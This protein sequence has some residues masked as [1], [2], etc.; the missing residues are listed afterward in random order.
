MGGRGF[1]SRVVF[2]F[3]WVSS[4]PLIKRIPKSWMK[5]LFLVYS[6]CRCFTKHFLH[7]N[8]ILRRC[9]ISN[10]HISN[11]MLLIDREVVTLVM[12]HIAWRVTRR[13]CLGCGGR[14]GFQRQLKFSFRRFEVAWALVC[15]N[16][17]PIVFVGVSSEKENR[18][19][20]WIT[21]A[22]QGRVSKVVSI[23]VA[24]IKIK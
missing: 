20:H 19:A 3:G 15:I 11:E 10:V 2:N 5:R 22:Y 14:E 24:Y 9:T 8:Q 17:G 6:N 1:G 23:K 13:T 16:V 18:E 7:R 4:D 12:S 21:G